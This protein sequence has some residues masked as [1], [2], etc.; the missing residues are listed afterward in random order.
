MVV[1]RLKAS[2]V[3][4]DS[5]TRLNVTPAKIMFLYTTYTYMMCYNIC[6]Y[7]TYVLLLSCMYVQQEKVI[8]EIKSNSPSP[9]DELTVQYLEALNKIFENGLLSKK[10]V[11]SGDADP[12]TNMQ[13]GLSFFVSWCIEQGMRTIMFGVHIVCVCML[14]LFNAHLIS[15]IVVLCCAYPLPPLTYM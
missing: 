4:R 6:I 15:C 14:I 5:W 2:H 12:L 7:C 9:Y 3:F 10:R 8:A 11:F 1:P 13:T